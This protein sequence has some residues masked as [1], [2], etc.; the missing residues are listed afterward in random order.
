MKQEEYGPR[1]TGEEYDRAIVDLQRDAPPI[2]TGEEDRAR[3]RRALDLAIDHR[4]GR[5]F[6]Q[7]RRD[8]LWAA[9]E[10]IESKRIWIGLKYLLCRLSGGRAHAQALTRALSSEYG[11]VLSP[12]E[13]EEFLGPAPHVLPNQDDQRG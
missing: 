6:P 4:L 8:E 11:K 9:S 3:R 1:L 12:S 5:R 13:L 7:A 2:P 10:R